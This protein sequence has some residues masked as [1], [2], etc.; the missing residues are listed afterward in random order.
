MA[1]LS[2]LEYPHP[3]L[4]RK[5]S[6]VN[7]EKSINVIGTLINDMF[8]TMYSKNGVGL[9]ATQV[10]IDMYLFVMDITSSQNKK[11]V[12]INPEII[13]KKDE[14]YDFEACLSFPG[15]SAKVR[16]YKTVK[17]SA[18]DC[19]GKKFVVEYAGL[20]S[21]CVQ[22]EIDHLNGITFF[23]HL[24]PLKRKI[25]EKKYKKINSK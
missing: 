13:S 20:E 17:V 14:I 18:F 1:K 15:V 22:H 16:R 12:F 9:A 6:F 8:E 7:Y 10:A 5:A 23:D 21:R 25:I 2:I 3:F 24:S 11:E 19:N 4:K